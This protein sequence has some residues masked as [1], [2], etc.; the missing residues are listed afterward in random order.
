MC[1]TLAAL[2]QT[3]PPRRAAAGDPLPPGAVARLGTARFRPGEAVQSVA[4]SAD[5]KWLASTGHGTVQLWETTG[6]LVRAWSHGYAYRVAFMPDSK[7]LLVCGSGDDG[8]RLYDLTTEK[9]FRQVGRKDISA[10]R[11]ALSADQQFLLLADPYNNLIRLWEVD[12]GRE[13][14]SWKTPETHIADLALSPDG[15]TAISLSYNLKEPEYHSRSALRVWDTATGKERYQLQGEKIYWATPAVSPDG[16][17]FAA[18]NYDCRIVLYDLATGKQLLRFPERRHSLRYLAFS[19]DG[20]RL[21]SASLSWANN[22]DRT[23]Y[24]VDLWDVATGKNLH[25]LVRHHSQVNAVAFS[26]DGKRLASTSLDKTLRIWDVATGKEIAEPPGHEAE[27][28][29][30]LFS[31]D[32]RLLASQGQ[33]G[34][35]R[36]WDTATWKEKR[37]HKGG[38]P[39]S[40]VVARGLRFSPD[41]TQ[42][43]GVGRGGCIHLWESVTGKKQGPAFCRNAYEFG[44]GFVAADFSPDG[45]WVAGGDQNGYAYLWAARTGKLVRVLLKGIGGPV[46]SLAFSPDGKSLVAG[47]GT[48]ADAVLCELPTG[49]EVRR[50]RITPWGNNVHFVTFSPDGRLVALGGRDAGVRLRDVRTGKIR[51]TFQSD[52]PAGRGAFSPD[53]RLFAAEHAAGYN[54]YPEG[55]VCLWEVATGKVC[56]RFAGHRGRL[57]AV[58]FSPDGRTLASAGAD[59][60]VLLWD[61]TGVLKRAASADR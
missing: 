30:L 38:S 13:L 52:F 16:K 34:T 29:A 1:L 35:L 27:V 43:L 5:G 21:A 57:S 3:D 59:T 40:L 39:D 11:F 8:S 61:V 32:G 54:S 10:Q 15:K 23:V 50:L 53:G 31:P 20:K 55:V 51:R 4:W 2:A 47:L 9:E 24:V 56:A 46:R 6:R 60:T 49:K 33:D 26:P 45:R 17:V 41:G 42:M 25:H 37:R 48:N 12:G 28:E 22:P 58:A 18:S 14:R 36:F 19:A 44:E 7:A